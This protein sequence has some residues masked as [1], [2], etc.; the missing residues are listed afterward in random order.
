MRLRR[1]ACWPAPPNT[2]LLCCLLTERHLTAAC[3]AQLLLDSS[4]FQW[5][6]WWRVCKQHIMSN[7]PLQRRAPLRWQRASCGWALGGSPLSNWPAQLSFKPCCWKLTGQSRGNPSGCRPIPI[8]DI[9]RTPSVGEAQSP[10]C[11]AEPSSTCSEISKSEPFAEFT[12][13][14]CSLHSNPETCAGH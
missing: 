3:P 4:V 8:P 10:L 14:P 11:C 9:Y 5:S 1:S 12:N 6:R 7:V 2:A 13:L